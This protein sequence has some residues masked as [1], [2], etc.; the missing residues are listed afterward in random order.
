MHYVTWNQI[1]S[2]P[3]TVNFTPISFFVELSLIFSRCV[4]ISFLP[5]FHPFFSFCVYPLTCNYLWSFFS[6]PASFY[7]EYIMWESACKYTYI[8]IYFLKQLLKLC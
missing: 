1:Y 6:I 3:F 4:P 7:A 2:N 5:S 8:K